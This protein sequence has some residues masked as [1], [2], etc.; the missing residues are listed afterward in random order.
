MGTS[1]KAIRERL[2]EAASEQHGL[3]T[4]KQA[5]EAGYADSTHKYHVENG[6]WVKVHRG[7]YRLAE[8]PQPD[9]EDLVVWSLWSRGR[10]GVPQGVYCR[11]T[12]LAIHG[13]IDKNGEVLHM[14]VPSSFRKNCEI[15]GQLRLYKED[16]AGRDVDRRSGYAVT[17]LARTVLDIVKSCTNPKILAIVDGIRAGMTPLGAEPKPAVAALIAENAKVSTYA[18]WDEYWQGPAVTASIWSNGR[19]FEDVLLA[20]ED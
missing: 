20:G 14:S 17:T 5:V 11:E 18:D 3:F 12:A 19:S 15:P 6:D 16:I 8:V 9:R 7:I 13:F 10:D 1:S 4:A 2:L